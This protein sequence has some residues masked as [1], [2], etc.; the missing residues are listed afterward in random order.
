M[1][2]NLNWQKFNDNYLNRE[3]PYEKYVGL[4]L[5]EPTQT[6]QDEEFERGFDE[7]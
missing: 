2:I 4:R 5:I 7:Y 1:K 6:W 3:N